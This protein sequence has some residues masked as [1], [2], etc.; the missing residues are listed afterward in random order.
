MCAVQTEI[1]F[2][3]F[4]SKLRIL[5]HIYL[6]KIKIKYYQSKVM[7]WTTHL[8]YKFYVLVNDVQLRT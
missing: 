7:P 8:F 5:K 6:R 1:L 2:F 4:A 3:I